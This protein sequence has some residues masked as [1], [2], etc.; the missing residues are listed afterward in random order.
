M[1]R[2]SE[3]FADNKPV[4]LRPYLKYFNESAVWGI[5]IPNYFDTQLDGCRKSA[6]PEVPFILLGGD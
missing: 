2:N 4:F 6:K 5:I 3:L 1:G